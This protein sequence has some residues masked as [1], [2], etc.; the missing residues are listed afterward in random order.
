MGTRIVTNAP[1]ERDWLPLSSA[2]RDGTEVEL[3]GT[4]GE[5]WKMRWQLLPAR[6]GGGIWA[7]CGFA[8]GVLSTWSETD[9]ECPPTHWRHIGAA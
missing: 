1:S 6:L 7:M 8:G 5:V 4:D 2:P 9:P 3:T